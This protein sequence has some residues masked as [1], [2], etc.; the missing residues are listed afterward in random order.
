[1]KPIDAFFSLIS[2]VLISDRWRRNK[3]P[4]KVV[5]SMPVEQREAL[6][7]LK[8]DDISPDKLRAEDYYMM[9]D[10]YENKLKMLEFEKK[11]GI[12]PPPRKKYES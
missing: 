9:G 5:E 1:M 2:R 7:Q 6:S 11:L 12:Q 10:D 8:S 4:G 3:E